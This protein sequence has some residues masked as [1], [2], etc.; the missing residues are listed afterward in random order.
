VSGLRQWIAGRLDAGGGVV[1]RRGF[2]GTLFAAVAVGVLDPQTLLWRP[3]RLS[4][5]PPLEPEALVGLRAITKAIAAEIERHWRCRE[6]TYGDAFMREGE[7]QTYVAMRVPAELDASGL[8]RARYIEP[9][10]QHLAQ[11][12]R[13]RQAVACGH[14]ALP[15]AWPSCLVVTKDTGIAVRGML[16]EPEAAYELG[17]TAGPALERPRLP[18]IDPILRFDIR[19]MAA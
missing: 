5:L 12:L 9:A 3:S 17:F 19:Y 1:N 6:P 18:P 13:D 4:G 11:S 8:D 14:L 16:I 7:T 10:G 2:L 15:A